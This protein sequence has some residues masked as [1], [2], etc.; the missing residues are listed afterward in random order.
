MDE[1][2]GVDALEQAKGILGDRLKLLPR[3]SWEPGDLS[4]RL[5][6]EP[7][8]RLAARLVEAQA[9][10]EIIDATHDDDD[11]TQAAGHRPPGGHRGKGDQ[12]MP[13]FCSV[14][15]SPGSTTS[16]S[17]RSTAPWR[18]HSSAD[19]TD[20]LTLLNGTFGRVE[21]LASL[22][23]LR[24]GSYAVLQ[25]TRES[26]LAGRVGDVPQLTL[27]PACPNVARDLKPRDGYRPR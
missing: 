27:P 20:P 26:S 17:R 18:K 15:G 5:V 21:K 1:L 24:L 14:G 10:E 22:L 2:D 23:V 3:L 25:A 8:A 19:A 13:S 9:S 11:A 7:H 4:A 16:S 6:N 12:P